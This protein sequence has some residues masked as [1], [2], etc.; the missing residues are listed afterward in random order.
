[1]NHSL[2]E[3][4]LVNT[5]FMLLLVQLITC[6]SN[7][8][9]N[10]SANLYKV[11]HIFT[12]IINLIIFT[13]LSTRWAFNQYFPLSN[14]YESL[15]F[16]TWSLTFIQILL[17][18]KKYYPQKLIGAI[19]TPMS[20]FTIA[21]ASLC[22]PHDMKSASPLVPALR[23]N[24]LV[25]HVTVMMVSYAT[26][27]IGSLLSILFL[28][29]SYGKHID[30]QGNSYNHKNKILMK[31][32]NNE[33][34]HSQIKDQPNKYKYQIS[35]LQGID[36]LSYRVIG[37]GFPLLTIGIISGAVWANEA[38]GTYWSWDPKETWALITWIIF[39][40]YLHSRLNHKTQQGKKPAIIASAGFIIIWICYLGVNFLGKGLHNYGWIIS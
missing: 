30:I 12:I 1:M 39:A 16:L 14:L 37:T 25:M 23:S 29:I 19:V 28:I 10:N 27:I 38:W 26:L 17:Q 11:S 9:I 18:S 2:F 31:Y 15:I 40:I 13:I 4:Y 22:L 20:L 21:F 35:L 33:L 3:N 24:W 36:N 32:V 8:L 34:N 7:L 6:W 5:T